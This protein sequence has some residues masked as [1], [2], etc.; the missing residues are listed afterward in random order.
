MGVTDRIPGMVP[1]Q[2]RRNIALGLLYLCLLPFIVAAI[3]LYLFFAVGTNRYN[4]A[5]RL[6]N[7]PLSRLPGLDR[8]GWTAGAATFVYVLVVF[9]LVGAAV[10]SETPDATGSESLPASATTT[11]EEVV[12]ETTI[13]TPTSVTST[14]T[15]GSIESSTTVSKTTASD[16]QSAVSSSA[17]ASTTT[18]S[19]T[20]V[21]MTT[22]ST[23]AAS[24]TTATTPATTVTTS[25]TTAQTTATITTT[26]TTT[27]T[28]TSSRTATTTQTTPQS[29]RTTW[30]V[31]VVQVVD[32]DTFE[33]RFPDGHTE[34]VRLLGV[35]TPEVHVENDP[36][37]F[38]S[39]PDT[40]AGNDWLRDW[41]H[42]A[43]E[44]ARTE[45]GGE[46]IKIEVD[47]Q[48]DRRGSYDRLLVYAY[49]DGEL[50]NKKLLRQGYARLY[51]S[52]FQKRASFGT[53]E[54]NSQQ[55]EVGL[56]SFESTT[57]TTTTTTSE[58]SNSDGGES[59]SVARLHV[60]ADGNDHENENGEYV[61]FENTGDSPIDFTG[62]SL[63][64]EADHVY[65]FPDGFTLE[66]GATVTVYTGSGSNSA[67]KLYWGSDSAIWNNGGDT[68]IVTTDTGNTVL[69]HEY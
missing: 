58:Q 37:E 68:I 50:F 23:T 67:S 28:T 40:R 42:K 18:T 2:T 11:G 49:D 33:V 57:A 5:D 1:G 25:T 9:A 30:N 56:W 31:T 41:G 44:F 53:I 12:S 45:L 35:D 66:P 4:L 64:D 60:D 52:E 38:E 16:S 59:L 15:E 39:I 46:Q 43:S 51:D 10:P 29:Q 6:A 24:T 48:A 32:G 62:W 61:V 27:R 14:E 21:S 63:R 69:E 7:S 26:E 54:A 36:A 20:T 8:G 65:Y 22:A 17:T 19:A 34:D 55:S 47:E 13:V 3:P